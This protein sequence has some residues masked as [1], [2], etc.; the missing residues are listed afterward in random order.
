MA[1]LV[2]CDKCGRI[3]EKSKQTTDWVSL[4]VWNLEDVQLHGKDLCPSCAQCL[5]FVL[6][7]K[8]FI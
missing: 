5:D 3:I 4:S 6:K 7:E 8:G 1:D 2:K